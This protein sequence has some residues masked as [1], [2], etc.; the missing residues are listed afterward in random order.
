MFFKCINNLVRK[1]EIFT[2]CDLYKKKRVFSKMWQH[3]WKQ[4]LF[5]YSEFEYVTTFRIAGLERENVTETYISISHMEILFTTVVLVSGKDSANPGH[6]LK[7][8]AGET[9][10]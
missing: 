6:N 8:G 10:T 7:M 5:H 3:Y 1:K 2:L 4:K 9:N